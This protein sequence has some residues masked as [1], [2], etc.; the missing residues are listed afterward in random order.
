MYTIQIHLN[1]VLTNPCLKNVKSLSS[2]CQGHQP[3]RNT[4]IEQ[5]PIIQ[6]EQSENL[7]ATLRHI[8][9]FIFL[10]I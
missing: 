7:R 9:L 8:Y 6:L 5:S 10:F 4:L 3:D 2:K 1:G